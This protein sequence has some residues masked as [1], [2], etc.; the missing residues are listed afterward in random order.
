[1]I[2]TM[3]AAYKLFGRDE[4]QEISVQAKSFY[5]EL[6]RDIP[7]LIK[8]LNGTRSGETPINSVVLWKP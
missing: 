3:D 7:V 8:I 5:D 1:M 2:R 6:C 4:D